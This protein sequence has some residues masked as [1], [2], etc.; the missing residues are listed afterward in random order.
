MEKRMKGPRNIFSIALV[1]LSAA[2]FA[3]SCSSDPQK[4]KLKYLAAGQSYMEKGQYGDAAIE[5]RNALRLDP[6]FVNAYYQ[7]AQASLARHD[8]AAAYGA[9]EKAIELNPARLD[10][11]LDRGRLYLAARQ[12]H[13]ADDEAN[14]ILKQEPGNIGAYQLLGAALIGE[15][16]PDKALVAFEK[17]TE[18]LPNSSSAYV[19]IALV[20]VTLHHLQDAE[21]HLKKAVSVDSTDTQAYMDLANFYRLQNRIPDAQQALQ[22]GISKNPAGTALYIDRASMLISQG[23]KEDAE[24]LLDKLRKQ[25][26]DSAD[27]AVAIGD[28]YFQQKETNR[29]LAEYQRGLSITPK[30]LEIKKRILDL[31]LS[32]GQT[33]LAA[34]LDRQL[35]KESPKDVTVRID[36]GRLLMAQGNILEAISNLQRVVVDAADSAQANYFLAMA[37]LQNDN[38]AQAHSALLEALKASPDLPIALQALSR[39]SLAQGD[40]SETVIYAQELV[41]KFPADQTYRQLLAEGLAHH[42]ETRRAEEQFLV[43]KRLTPND[44]SVHLGLAQLYSAEKKWTEA[45]TEFETILQLDPHNTT[46]L[47]QLADVLIA[48]N[49]SSQ[50]SSLVQQYVSANPN[51]ANGHVLLGALDAGSKNYGTAQEEFERSIKLDPNNVQAYLRLGQTYEV[52]GQTDLA[53]QRYQKA[54]DLQPKLAPLATMIGNLYLNKK[55]LG[56]ARKYYAQALESDPS[57][58]VAN[59]NMAWVDVQQGKN[60]DVALSRAQKAKSLMPDAPSVTDTLAWVMYKRG[61]YAAAMPLLQECVQKSPDS[62]QFHYHLGL[63]LIAAGQ[64]AKG[65]EQLEN[66]LRLK[67][68]NADAQQAQQLLAAAN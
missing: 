14:F 58:A 45:Q 22:D 55:D 64:K 4:A 30:S 19:N 7:L 21:R 53:I 25:P 40:V 52:Q 24:A 66:A 15:Q 8:W 51:D 10:A 42:G 63:T 5:F 46:A 67:L 62:S 11:R 31:Y 32:T 37:Y 18:L 28:F 59:A 41:D 33:Q 20:E 61:N 16:K 27:A 12:F 17:V 1:V 48:R 13:E 47:G 43:A 38:V 60:L 36:H 35:G 50:A 2:L 3:C 6:R 65:R 29:A 68:D 26:V 57:F 23:Q 34:E 9:L 54:L 56:M 44:P 49:Q 39:L